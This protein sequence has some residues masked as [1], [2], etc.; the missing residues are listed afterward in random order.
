MNYPGRTIKKGESDKAIIKAI[1]HQLNVKECG[2][3]VEDGD[4]GQKTTNAIKL[5]QMRHTDQNG[6]PLEVDGKLGA[7]SW[8]VLFGTDQKMDDNPDSTLLAKVVAI[9]KT[10]IGVEEDKKHT[11]RGPEVEAYQ[12]SVGI[13]PG[14]PWCASFVY[15]CFEQAAKELG[16][17]NPVYKTGHVLTHWQKAGC[18]KIKQ[19][20]A[21]QNPA[22]I[23]PGHIF[24]MDHG[25]GKGHTGI[26]TKVEGGFIHTIE[27]NT[28]NNRSRDGYGVFTLTRKVNAIKKGFLDYSKV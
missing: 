14:S 15:W 4:F 6:H 25:G 8:A 26:V 11:N 19:L 21:I 16:V 10:Q 7:I 24:M 1:Q 17:P 18:R 22:I 28:N 23:K 13:P 12:K 20:D 2:P 5:F 27:G 3:L 9:A